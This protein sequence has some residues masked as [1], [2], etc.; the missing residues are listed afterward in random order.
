M[1][2]NIEGMH[3]HEEQGNR[4]FSVGHHPSKGPYKRTF[5]CFLGFIIVLVIT[6]VGLVIW[7]SQKED[8]EGDDHGHPADSSTNN[9]HVRKVARP[10]H[11]RASQRLKGKSSFTGQMF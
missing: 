5:Y 4:R 9:P 10:L 6:F 2:C 3:L 1:S 8:W 7:L 11:Y